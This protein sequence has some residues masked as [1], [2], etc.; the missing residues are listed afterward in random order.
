MMVVHNDQN[1]RVFIFHPKFEYLLIVR[2]VHSKVQEGSERY[3]TCSIWSILNRLSTL[4]LNVCEQLR[5][6]Y[7]YRLEFNMS[8]K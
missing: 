2:I 8:L 5:E 6:Q 1:W 3:Y 4:Q 7:L